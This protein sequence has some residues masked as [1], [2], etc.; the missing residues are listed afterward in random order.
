MLLLRKIDWY[1]QLLLASCMVLSCFVLSSG[2]VFLVGLLFLGSWQLL[3]A[4]LNTYSFAQYGFTRRIFRYWTC[5]LTDL[6][7]FFF[8]SWLTSTS[9]HLLAKMIFVTSLTGALAVAGYYWWIY[10]KLMGFLFLR[11]ELDGLTKSKH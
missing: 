11:N 5:C 9:T 3:S 7:S 6:V 8:S 1:G 10:Y 4:I 2:G